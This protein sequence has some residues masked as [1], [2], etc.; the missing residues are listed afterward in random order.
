MYTHTHTESW[1]SASQEAAC[2]SR[3]YAVITYN[4]IMHACID[5][6]SSLSPVVADLLSFILVNAG[7]FTKAFPFQYAFAHLV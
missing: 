5:I 6:T 2:L 3:S 1:E 7:A 4:R